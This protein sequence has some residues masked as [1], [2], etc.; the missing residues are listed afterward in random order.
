[1]KKIKVQVIATG[2]IFE[3]TQHLLQPL[4]DSGRVVIIEEKEAKA[5]IETKEE[6]FE[7]ETK[8]LT[9]TAKSLNT[10]KNQ[11]RKRGPKAK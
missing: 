11:Q 9:I 3:E 8:D 6:K 2:Q 7:P 1:M 10:P 4:I 5:V